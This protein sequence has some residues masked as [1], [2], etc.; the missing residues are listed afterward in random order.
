MKAYF[1][2]ALALLALLLVAPRA[3]AQEPCTDGSTCSSGFCVDDVCCD[4]E[5]DGV[6]QGCSAIA[7]GGGADGVCGQAAE[8]TVCA[9]SECGTATFAFTPADTCDASGACV[10]G[11][12]SVSCS[13]SDGVCAFD[14]CHD[15]NGCEVV[16]AAD[17][18]DC[19][20]DMSCFD[21]V[22]GDGVPS[23]GAGLGG[24]NAGGD[25]G[26]AGGS[27]GT[28]FGGSG[29][30]V[31]GGGLD[32]NTGCACSAPSRPAS[33]NIFWLMLLLGIGLRRRL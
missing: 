32:V 20:S 10:D 14:L 2:F 19:G 30:A 29:G 8:G 7:K 26:D 9:P 5:C 27:T 1:S 28:G 21:G 3:R 12:P 17:G 6:C 15:Q 18:T 11:G 23:T 22:C 31:E 24:M 13:Q 25:P 33:S 4:T 16:K